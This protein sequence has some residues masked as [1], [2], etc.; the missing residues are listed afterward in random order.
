MEPDRLE[1]QKRCAFNA[2]CKRVLE[3]EAANAHRDVKQT[4]V[5]IVSFSDLTPQEAAQLYSQDSYFEDESGEAFLVG[6][7]KITTKLLAEALRT[8]PRKSAKLSCCTTFLT[9]P[10]WKLESCFISR[11]ARYSIG[12]QAHSTC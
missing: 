11:A 7:K 2:F 4:Q 8:L 1:W 10:M 5:K 9:S 3:N 12:G 6:G